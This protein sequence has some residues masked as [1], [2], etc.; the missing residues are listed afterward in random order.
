MT[1]LSVIIPGFNTPEIWWRRCLNTIRTACGPDDE[2]LCVDDGSNI[3]PN[4][5]NDIAKEDSRV[6]PIFLLK[7]KGQAFSRNV[8]LDIAKGE[9]ISFVDSDD[10]IIP[11][12]YE[13]CFDKQ[14]INCCDIVLYGVRVIWINEHL[15]KD[16]IPQNWNTR[17]LNVEDIKYL[18]DGCLFEYTVNR[19]YRKV[20]LK[21]NKIRIDEG[22]CPGEDTIFNLKCI[23]ANAHYTFEPS[24]GYIYYRYYNSSLARYQ[25]KFDE[26]IR[27]RNNL[28]REVKKHCGNENVNIPKLG[29]LSDEELFFWDIQNDWRYDSPISLADR[30]KK[31]IKNRNLLPYYPILIFL[32]QIVAYF[33]RNHLY[34]R[35]IRRWKIK[36]MFTNVKELK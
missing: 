7:N 31:I 12:I 26:S 35:F 24:I 5:L 16:D 36:N 8:A 1:R 20:F 6:K 9:W 27:I 14:E 11:S 25:E 23:M 18:F 4:F 10:E 28:W 30:W 17:V 19:I 29:E 34:Y 33:V 13:K 22:I 15:Y 3:K 21:N 32:R 2:I